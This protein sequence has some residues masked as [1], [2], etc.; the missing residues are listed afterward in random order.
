ML[1]NFGGSSS[2]FQTQ[3]SRYK[4]FHILLYFF[5]ASKLNGILIFFFGGCISIDIKQI[6]LQL[7]KAD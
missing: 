4:Y 7:I 1:W 5:L 6:S 2:N 3:I